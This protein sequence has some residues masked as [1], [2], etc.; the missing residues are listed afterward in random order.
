MRLAAL[1]ADRVSAAHQSLLP[2]YTLLS[3]TLPVN[4]TYGVLDDF[5]A[6]YSGFFNVCDEPGFLYKSLIMLMFFSLP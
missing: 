1:Q 5:P 3:K 4:S 6:K 2:F